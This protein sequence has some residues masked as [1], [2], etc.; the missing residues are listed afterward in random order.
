VSSLAAEPR[1]GARPAASLPA[2]RTAAGR[3]PGIAL[4]SGLTVGIFALALGAQGGTA[5]SRGTW[6]EVLVTVAG[7]AAAVAA[8]LLG[9]A[10]R[11]A[12]GGMSVGLFAALAAWTALSI[13]WAV[14]PDDAWLETNRTFSYLAAFTG[15][16]A[17]A[18]LAPR[19]WSALLAAV[20]AGTTAVAVYALL[21]KVLPGVVG[22]DDFY[23]R[24]RAPFGYWNAVGLMAALGVPACLWLG[25]R[26]DGHGALGALAFPATGLLL[27]TV[28]LAASRG[29]VLAIAIGL[30][31]WFA[32]V[33]LRLRALAVLAPAAVGA[34]LL[35][36]WSAAR[37]GLSHD[38]LPTAVRA[39]AGHQLGVGLVLLVLVLGLYGLAM[40]F[41]FDHG[42][43]P[44]ASRRRAGLVVAA[45]A[46]VAVVGGLIALQTRP[47]GISGQVSSTWNKFTDP[48][49]SPPNNDPSRLT[50]AGSVRARY[51][52]EALQVWRAHPVDGAG[53]GGFATARQ[54]YSRDQLRVRHAHGY[55]VQTLA[56]LGLV[57]AGLSLALLVAWLIAAA[58]TAPLRARAPAG[59]ERIGALTLLTVVVV[60]GVHSLVDWTWFIPAPAVLALVLAGWLAG[61]GPLGEPRVARERRP[62][63]RLIPAA[64][65]VALAAVMVW[66]TVAPLR[67]QAARDDSQAHLSH[68]RLGAAVAAAETAAA[69]DPLSPEPLYDLAAARDAAGNR[70]AARAAL[71]QA[72]RLAPNASEPWLRLGEYERDTLEAPRAAGRS[73]AAALALDPH[74]PAVQSAFA[75]A[76]QD[77]ARRTSP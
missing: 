43:L 62:G 47:G 65:V 71:R 33:P 20:A 58:R 70:A 75:Q 1:S 66:A 2:R 45:V 38:G 40:R 6:A 41:T 48:N 22:G 60:F 18:R 74:S 51:W 30:A 16:A 3:G 68:G 39:V 14:F 63:W 11:R 12:W 69:R 29:S 50:Q 53:A 32:C 49:A 26:R 73:L 36:V 67:S 24:L 77:A 37:P 25:A 54:R 13:G 72:V 52:D 28:L 21:S 8:L 42:P 23:A 9:P 35:A 46:A 57:G 56:D 61:R 64:G 7:A 76:R 59:P 19:R 4:A 15:G 55:V 17:L 5:L 34:V 27:V 44:A 10:T 31:L